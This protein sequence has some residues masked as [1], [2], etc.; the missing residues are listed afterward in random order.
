MDDKRIV[1]RT[2]KLQP[3]R[4]RTRGK[5][6]GKKMQQYVKYACEEQ[7]EEISNIGTRLQR[8]EKLSI[9]K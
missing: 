4:M 8:L 7:E 6:K 3:T 9:N 1:R 5:H 2:D